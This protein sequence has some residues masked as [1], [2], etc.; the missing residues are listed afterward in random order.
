MQV[1]SSQL[2]RGISVRTTSLESSEPRW[3]HTFDPASFDQE[4][5]ETEFAESHNSL[6][7]FTSV[8][9]DTQVVA[10]PCFAGKKCHGAVYLHCENTES[11][12][13][14][15][16]LWQRTDRG[17]LGMTESWYAN[18]DRLE[19]V[20]QYIKFPRR[21]GLPGMVW[22]DR[23]PRVLG[24]LKDSKSFVRVAAARSDSLSAAL[25]V[26]F[27][28]SPPDLDAVLLLLNSAESPLARVIEVW[29]RDPESGK[30]KI[31]SAEYGS[32]VDLAPVS[33][34]LTLGE[35]EGIAGHVFR[36]E[37]PWLTNDLLGVE[38][39]RG[40]AFK[41][42]GLTTGVG[43]PVFIGSKLIACINLYL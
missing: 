11:V 23:F 8:S 5:F 22:E 20:S 17:E 36:N 35:S 41:N 32:L 2:V 27:M 38:F 37:S 9:D 26:P 24:S 7:T 3:L 25:G 1:A 42:D 29:S 12:R 31:V 39:P 15:F 16:E 14:A 13:G 4:A 34:R 28:Q 21:A 43:I 19:Q 40:E 18:L 30:L 6:P 33:R 10:W